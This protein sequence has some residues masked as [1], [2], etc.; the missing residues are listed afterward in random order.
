[1]L[2][3][4]HRGSHASSRGRS[5]VCDRFLTGLWVTVTSASTER[6]PE[7]QPGEDTEEHTCQ[8]EASGC[9]LLRGGD[10]PKQKADTHDRNGGACHQETHCC[11][12]HLYP[13][14]SLHAPPSMSLPRSGVPACRSHREPNRHRSIAGLCA[15]MLA[16]LPM[17]SSPH[18]S[19]AYG[20][21]KDTISARICL[22]CTPIRS[23]Q[24]SNVGRWI[25]G[26][27]KGEA[28]HLSSAC[29]VAVG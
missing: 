23:K 28:S 26:K 7:R 16:S 11:L 27:R 19:K 12:Q 6:Y 15:H 24:S 10:P 3:E 29:P 8:H 20:L 17:T 22:N 2:H 21:H 25:A 13:P 1:V 4:A 9:A 5:S 18:S 14:F